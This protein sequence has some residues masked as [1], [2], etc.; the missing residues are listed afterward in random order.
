MEP[1]HRGLWTGVSGYFKINQNTTT[2]RPR[3][4]QLDPFFNLLAFGVFLETQWVKPIFEPLFK[5]AILLPETHF[6]ASLG[7]LLKTRL[8]ERSP[9]PKTGA[10][11]GRTELPI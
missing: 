3:A 1:E 7:F 8:L 11:F 9:H 5:P 2:K 10:P 6:K 4:C